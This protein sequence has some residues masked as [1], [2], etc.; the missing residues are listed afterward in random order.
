MH[1][2]VEGGTTKQR[3]LV[4][5][6]AA[7]FL[8]TLL[9][10]QTS[11]QFQVFIVLR[12]DYYKRYGT[13]ADCCIDDD[14]EIAEKSAVPCTFE[15][16]VDSSMNNHGILRSIAHEC[17]H[18]AQ[19]R[20]GILRESKTDHKVSYWR[21]QKYRLTSDNYWDMPWEVDAYGREIGLVE[22]FVETANLRK[23]KWY[24]IDYDYS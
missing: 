19:W 24:K 5:E 22:R 4:E 12:K 17:A 20:Q 8:R 15:I 6:A 2:F 11:E 18:I 21:G 7:F 16:C 13:K 10:K 1:V 9:P 14:D 23:A 3:S